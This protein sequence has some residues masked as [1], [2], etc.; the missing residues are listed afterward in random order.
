M[1]ILSQRSPGISQ[2]K[3]RLYIRESSLSLSHFSSLQGE[4]DCITDLD[5]RQLVLG[6]V[7]HV[8]D[9]GQWH[10]VVTLHGLCHRNIAMVQS[11][12]QL[13]IKHLHPPPALVSTGSLLPLFLYSPPVTIISFFPGDADLQRSKIRVWLTRCLQGTPL[14]PEGSVLCLVYLKYLETNQLRTWSKPPNSTRSLL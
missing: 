14:S 5:D 4:G 11:P 10:L 8:S 1:Y 3:S 12:Y 7:Q 13:F 6:L 2:F 9:S